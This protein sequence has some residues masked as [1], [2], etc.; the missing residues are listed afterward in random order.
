MRKF[1]RMILPCLMLLICAAPRMRAQYVSANIVPD[2]A[3][4]Q[5]DQLRTL[6]KS[7]H[8]PLVLQVGSHLLFQE[9]H[10]P[11]SK[12]AGPGSQES[13]LK[14]LQQA[15]SSLPKSHAVVL[16][17]GCCPWDRCPNIGPAWQRLHQMGYSNVKVLYLPN[18][19]GD[20][21]AARGYPTERQ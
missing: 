1:S 6:L 4:M 10:I 9:A 19:F 12:Y 14:A 11:G 3:R 15:V 7:N 5:P 2:A 16:Y 18:N 13:G 21:W 8:A 20:D 17:C